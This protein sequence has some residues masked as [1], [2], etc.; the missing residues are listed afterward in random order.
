MRG[1]RTGK[2]KKDGE[3]RPRPPASL[4]LPTRRG[5]CVP[6]GDLLGPAA[7]PRP[8]GGRRH[9]R[10]VEG[11]ARR[12]RRGRGRPQGRGR[13]ARRC[14][15][16]RHR[17]RHYCLSRKAAAAPELPGADPSGRPG[18]GA[19]VAPPRRPSAG[20]YWPNGT[21]ARERAGGGAAP[22]LPSRGRR[23]R[24]ARARPRDAAGSAPGAAPRPGMGLGSLRRDQPS[25]GKGLFQ[26]GTTRNGDVAPAG[27]GEQNG[28]V[29]PQRP[30]PR[31]GTKP[32]SAAIMGWCPFAVIPPPLQ[33]FQNPLHAVLRRVP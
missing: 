12:S 10:E 21:G 32:P 8:R 30:S 13:R 17:L 2:E 26:E 9:G 23:D 24:A 18:R 29:A 5:Q 19:A 33:L 3:E 14:L 15:Q 16:R 4:P 1:E 20:S 6:A 22:V 11:D 27:G 31:A 25:A 28:R 7:S